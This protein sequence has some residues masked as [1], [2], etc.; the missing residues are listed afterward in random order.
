ML[1]NAGRKHPAA[2]G[3]LVRRDGQSLRGTNPPSDE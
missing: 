2:E 1:E 3:V